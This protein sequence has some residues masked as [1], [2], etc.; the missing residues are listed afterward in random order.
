MVGAV[1]DAYLLHRGMVLRCAIEDLRIDHHGGEPKI[2]ALEHREAEQ[3]EAAIA[4]PHA[5]A[6]E[7][8]DQDAEEEA[9]ERLGERAAAL[10]SEPGDNVV[11]IAPLDQ[12]GDLRRVETPV[13][14]HEEKILPGGG[15]DAATDRGPVATVAR[16]PHH[17]NGRVPGREV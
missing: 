16:V 1:M 8:A 2:Q 5:Y 3:L 12:A 4:V 9:H 7:H 13:S 6:E 14:V 11:L 10:Q 15:L 17:A